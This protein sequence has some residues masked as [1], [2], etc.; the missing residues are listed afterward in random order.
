MWG[1]GQTE[2]T[3]GPK[4]FKKK[5]ACSQEKIKGFENV[6]EETHNGFK[7]N[8]KERNEGLK[9]KRGRKKI[10]HTGLPQE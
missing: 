4:Y 7:N 10:K 1:K 9:G 8:S 6:P 5:T 3:L 2:R